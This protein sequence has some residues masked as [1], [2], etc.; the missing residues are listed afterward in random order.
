MKKY[1]LVASYVL[2]SVVMV[3]VKAYGIRA[4]KLIIPEK[5]LVRADELDFAK[6]FSGYTDSEIIA[7][8]VVVSVLEELIFRGAIPYVTGTSWIAGMI[9]A[10]AFAC[11]HSVKPGRWLPTN[12]PVSQLVGGIWYWLGIKIYGLPLA[13]VAHVI[14]NIII[15]RL[16]M[17]GLEKKGM[18]LGELHANG[19]VPQ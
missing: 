1:A 17:R 12:V 8:V 6:L 10:V 19:V 11:V 9:V 13:I 15:F 5:W 7:S 4:L 18:K 16:V 2:G 3:P 14:H